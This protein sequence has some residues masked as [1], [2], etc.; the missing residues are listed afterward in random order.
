MLSIEGL[1]PV[2]RAAWGPD[3]CDPD[4]RDQWRPD[5][6]ARAQC[7]TTAL[8]VQDLLGGDL[9]LA[10]VRVAGVKVGH[11]YWNRLPDGADVDLTAGQFRPEEA[12]VGGEVQRRPPEG[13]RRCRGEYELLRARVFWALGLG[14]DGSP[15]R[16]G[17]DR[18]DVS[19][20][21]DFDPAGPN[22]SHD[23]R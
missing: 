8:V 10:E 5:N 16:P 23:V 11:H 1:G 21:I 12:V 17:R 20:T 19:G 14:A 6:P 18:A 3:T 22:A 7:G 9:I 13:P 2:F 15:G 4:A